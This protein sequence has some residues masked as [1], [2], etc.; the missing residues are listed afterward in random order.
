MKFLP[1]VFIM[2]AW[3]FSPAVLAAG[4]ATSLQARLSAS[5]V[6]IQPNGA[7]R[8]LPADKARPGDVIEY[9]AIY[10]NHGTAPA[11]NVQATLPIPAGSL[12]Y[13]PDAAQLRTVHASLDGKRFD[14]IPLQRVVRLADGKPV[15]RPVPVSEY[16]FLRWDLGDIAAGGSATASSRMRVISASARLGAQK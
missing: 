15:M 12:E 14:A 11:R 5:K 9:Q 1:F 10:Q 7:E 16:R 6:T 3:A 8:L 4:A 13:L 2:M